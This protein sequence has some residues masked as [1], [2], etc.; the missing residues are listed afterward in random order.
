MSDALWEEFKRKLEDE[1]A[2]WDHYGLDADFVS[3]LEEVGYK[4]VLQRDALKARWQREIAK[5]SG[6]AATPSVPAAPSPPPPAPKPVSAPSTTPKSTDTGANPPAAA[7]DRS[8]KKQKESAPPPSPRPAKVPKVST[9]VRAPAP[10]TPKPSAPS[11]PVT[12]TPSRPSLPAPRPK[13]PSGPSH[14]CT[15]AS[16]DG[17]LAFCACG[18]A[19]TTV[20]PLWTRTVSK[21]R[22]PVAT[23]DVDDEFAVPVTDDRPLS[24]T[25]CDK[26]WKET[27]CYTDSKQ[28]RGADEGLTMF[29]SCS[30]CRYNF[31]QFS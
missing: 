24:M 6:A 7:K 28:T 17:V 30:I 1:G 26:C 25:F 27:P 3:I 2:E 29:Y 4:K 13:P 31:S 15:E 18:S 21:G 14:N 22:V 16:F 5:L 11:V 23:L 19:I 9:V 8:G 12:P 20:N 10:S